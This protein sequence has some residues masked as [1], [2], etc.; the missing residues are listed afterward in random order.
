LTAG[1][2]YTYYLIA[3][4]AVGSSGPSNTATAT[5]DTVP[6]VPGAFTVNAVRGKKR[7]RLSW[8]NATGESRYE[9]WRKP[10]TVTQP[11]TYTRLTTLPADATRYVDK[12][13][14]WGKRY[15]YF[16]KAVNA[17]GD[18]ESN[19]DDARVSKKR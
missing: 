1:A 2:T 11:G 9:V 3:V 4:N 14:S 17:L 18:T 10:G 5:L 16:V 7:L 15:S 8:L 13:V 12:Q 19:K 6:S